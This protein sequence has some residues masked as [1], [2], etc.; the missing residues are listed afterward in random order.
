MFILL[1][2][3]ASQ[4]GAAERNL[5]AYGTG[6]RIWVAEVLT[7]PGQE[8]LATTIYMRPIGEDKW[9]RV[10]TIQKRALSIQELQGELAVLLDDGSWWL[11]RPAT[12]TQEAY[13][14]IGRS[15]PGPIKAMASD[16][17]TL[18]A[19]ALAPAEQP[20]VTTRPTTR[21]GLEMSATPTTSATTRAGATPMLF[22]LRAGDW[23]MIAPVPPELVPGGP[24]SC[25]TLGVIDHA[26]VLAVSKVGEQVQIHRLTGGRWQAQDLPDSPHE[27][28]MVDLFRRDGVTAMLV[29]GKESCAVRK[30]LSAE[31]PFVV[32]ADLLPLPPL[33]KL[34]IVAAGDREFRLIFRGPG[35]ASQLMERRYDLSG[36][37]VRPAEELA[38]PAPASPTSQ[39]QNIPVMLLVAM[40]LI[41]LSTLRR[42]PTEQQVQYILRRVRPAPLGR[43]AAAGLID[44][45]PALV[46]ALV[47]AWQ[48]ARSGEVPAELVEL[49]YS[50]VALIGV[51][52]YL[53]HTTAIEVWKGRSVGKILLGLYVTTSEGAPPSKMSLVVRNALRL[54]DVV[55]FPPLMLM[56]AFSPVHQRLADVV[57]GTVVV[58][59]GTPTEVEA[60][61]P[62]E[63]ED[64]P[65]G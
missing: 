29:V 30:D 44:L 3:L 2:V 61:P 15:A 28:Q 59:P 11:V 31:D 57:A 54:I 45:S 35:K 19:I 34:A 13:Q 20:A 26:P 12:S 27:T 40:T 17:S 43:R 53:L 6:D 10:G 25:A 8:N 60:A 7:P 64:E 4:A 41:L 33:D 23:Q 46:A 18:W 37:P 16:G 52:L 36:Q 58:L 32:L 5:L 56:A 63:A 38:M 22:Q 24:A 42:R 47:A 49:V 1:L 21:R 62:D 14:R 39:L 50:P 51:G 9:Q 55:A 65:P 48:A